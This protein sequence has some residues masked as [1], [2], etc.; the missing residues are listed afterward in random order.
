MSN[1]LEKIDASIEELGII[2]PKLEAA[3]TNQHG[4]SDDGWW[5]TPWPVIPQAQHWLLSLET[6]PMNWIE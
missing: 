6:R 2:L 1:Y 4:N 3:A 5:I